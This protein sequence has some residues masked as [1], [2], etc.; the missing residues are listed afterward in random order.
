MIVGFVSIPM[1]AW[2]DF[3]RFD[4]IPRMAR[5][6]YLAE[7]RHMTMWGLFANLIDGT[8]SSIVVAKTFHSPWLIP[9]V[10]ATPMLAHL[11]TFVWGIVIRGRPRVRT[12]V[13]LAV[14]AVAAAGSIALTPSDRP[15][16]GWLFAGQVALA[17]IFLSGLV[18]VRT[19][20]WKANYP[21]S[22]RARI[23]GRIQALS[24]LL[25]IVIG[26]TVSILF[27][28]HAEYYRF[29]YPAIAVFGVL[30]LLPLR[31]MRIRGER[32]E[33][34]QFH[35]RSGAAAADAGVWTWF[36]QQVNEATAILRRDRPFARYCTA[37]YLLGSSNFMTDPVL[38]DFL[39]Q[40]LG[41]GYFA[42]YLLME[43][44]PTVVSLVTIR[45]WAH[46]FDRVGVLRFRVINTAIW[47]LSVALACAALL[48]YR[49]AFTGF[50]TLAI[51]VLVLGRLAN[52][53]ARGGGSIAWN[54]GHLHFAGEHDADL[55]MGIHVALTGV[56]GLIMPFVGIA[57]YRLVGPPVM[58]LGVGLGAAALWAFRRLALSDTSAPGGDSSA[59]VQAAADG[60]GASSGGSA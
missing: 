6:N 10:W 37:Q 52:G 22:H 50:A 20:M 60:G 21:R 14:C 41:L 29:V 16:A 53:G 55:Y 5:P 48:L 27:D 46:L 31:A 33:L 45:P 58:L 26:A 3:L 32:R 42:S 18:S 49:P 1:R 35:A 59:V 54:L 13:V 12:F 11:L 51:A 57:L 9:V 7:F 39:T 47:L 17:R 34:A 19:S 2:L 40:G 36:R 56:R 38:T 8:F 4:D 30:S 23:A 44:L 25:T 24:A 43:Q 15:W 28:Q